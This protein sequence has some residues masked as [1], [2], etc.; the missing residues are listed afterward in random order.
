MAPVQSGAKKKRPPTF[1]HFPEKRARA[2]KKTW[3][4][5]AKIK[6]QWKAEKRK[7]NLLGA[8]RPAQDDVEED[9][10][11]SEVQDDL[12]DSQVTSNQSKR[13]PQTF[14]AEAIPHRDSQPSGS[15]SLPKR[16]KSS[17]SHP[18]THPRQGSSSH[19]SAQKPPKAPAPHPSNRQATGRTKQ[20]PTFT[21]TRHGQPNMGLRMGAMLE[22]IKKDFA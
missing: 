10:N 20:K 9:G 16:N 1:Q 17:H 11:D 18:Q 13:D 5:T 19:S 2:L 12:A 15:M 6:S 14:I 4:E 8:A 3:V 7:A 22:K 21:H